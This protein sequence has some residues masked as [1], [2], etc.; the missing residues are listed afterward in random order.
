MNLDGCALSSGS[1]SLTDS[2]SGLA[3]AAGVGWM[4]LKPAV[5]EGVTAGLEGA[6]AW[7]RSATEVGG[8]TC[9]SV[10][11]KKRARL[12]R[13]KVGGRAE[14]VPGVRT[15]CA[16]LRSALLNIVICVRNSLA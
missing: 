6:A 15:S 1:S 10:E 4:G 5:V 2:E 14:G 3:G 13:R 11:L 8:S 7:A 9:W 16:A 12:G